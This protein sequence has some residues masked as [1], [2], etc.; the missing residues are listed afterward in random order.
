MVVCCL[1]AVGAGLG[2]GRG[3][4]EQCGYTFATC[5]VGK[6]GSVAAGLSVNDVM[7]MLVER[8]NG[9]SAVFGRA[10]LLRRIT[11]VLSATCGGGT[12]F[13]CREKLLHAGCVPRGGSAPVRS[14]TLVDR[15]LWFSELELEC[16]PLDVS[17]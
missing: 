11:T 4:V 5:C 9:S 6:S 8:P 12:T 16:T 13:L 7:R 15:G 3:M 1:G 14:S 17:L 10:C 2:A